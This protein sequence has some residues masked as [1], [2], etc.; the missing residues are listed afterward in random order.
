MAHRGRPLSQARN[1]SSRRRFLSA[2]L[3]GLPAKAERKVAGRIVD[4]SHLFGHRLRDRQ[5]FAAPKREAKVPVVIAGGGMAGLSAGWRLLKRGFRDF[6]ILEMETEPGGNSRWGKNEISEYPWAAH[7]LPIPNRNASLVRELCR[8][9]GLLQEDGHFAERHLCHSPQ[10][11]LFIHGRWQDGIEPESGVGKETRE[12]YRRFEELIREAA[13]TGQFTVPMEDGLKPSALDSVSMDQ[14]LRQ[15]RLDSPFLRWYVN[16]ATRDD[17]GLLAGQTS[18]WAGIHYFAAREHEDR[19]PLVWPEG[20]GFIVKHLL[21]Q[22]RPYIRPSS[23]VFR[24][25]DGRTI[26]VLTEQADYRAQCVIWA[27]PTFLLPYVFEGAPD[28]G[29]LTYSPWWTANLTLQRLPKEQYTQP[30]WDNVIYDSPSLGYVVATHQSLRTH[31]DKSVWTYYFA[32]A[33]GSP[34]QNRKLLLE[35]DWA[36][37]RDFVLRDLERAH[38]DIR[39]CVSHID[40]MRI[41]HAM[42]RP[43]PGR[44]LG[45]A[46]R[47]L[48]DWGAGIVPA[49]S[50]LSGLSIFEEAQYRGVRAADRALRRLGK[51]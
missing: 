2:A 31:I 25:E 45:E 24:I 46:R 7:Y 43:T 50:D 19:G 1:S 21:K 30:A 9:M 42:A 15:N 29:G 41:G 35:R 33:E 49:N 27:A 14:W 23:M 39:E 12:Q 36:Y 40:V 22:L 37:Y 51:G 11:R 18:A 28:T 13:A 20:N 6:V 5:K 4:D 34:E 38:P 8:E 26:R 10:E 32:M 48:A 17:Y 16:Y 47:R 44:I 3:I